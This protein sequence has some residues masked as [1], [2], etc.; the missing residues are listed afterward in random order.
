MNKISSNNNDDKQIIKCKLSVGNDNNNN[1]D[2]NV[3]ESS[4]DQ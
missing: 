1:K 3:K 2:A 4:A